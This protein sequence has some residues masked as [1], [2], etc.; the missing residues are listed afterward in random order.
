V[1]NTN[2]DKSAGAKKLRTNKIE[3]LPDTITSRNFPL[4]LIYLNLQDNQV[5][6]MTEI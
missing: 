4:N 2:K 5:P 1:N 3:G 6:H